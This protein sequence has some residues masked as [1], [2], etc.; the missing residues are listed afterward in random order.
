MKL[1]VSLPFLIKIYH[2]TSKKMILPITILFALIDA[3]YLNAGYR[4]ESHFSRWILRLFVVLAMSTDWTDFV[5]FSAV[6]YLVFD[7]ALNYFRKLPI[8][9]IGSTSKIDKFWH[10]KPYL[11]LAFKIIFLLLAITLK[12]IT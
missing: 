4:F 11:Q 10:D 7:Y 5:L 12:I 8:L 9:Y 1:I 2:I 6:L 3:Q